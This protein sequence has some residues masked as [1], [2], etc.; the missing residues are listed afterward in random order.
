M[1]ISLLMDIDFGYT[2][3][4]EKKLET[5]SRHK[6]ESFLLYQSKTS[7]HVGERGIEK[8]GGFDENNE[9]VFV[10]RI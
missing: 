1:F 9:C 2:N 4:E 7:C 3:Q 8:G 6:A 10:D 5:K